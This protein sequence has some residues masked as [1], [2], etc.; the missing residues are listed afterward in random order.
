MKRWIPLFAVLM[1]GCETS[2]PDV[3]NTRWGMSPEQVKDTETA[4]L[5]S[6]KEYELDY[7][8]WMEGARWVE[9]Q[10]RFYGDALSRVVVDINSLTDSFHVDVLRILTEKYGPP[11][12]K[13]DQEDRLGTTLIRKWITPRTN[14]RFQAD[15]M[16]GIEIWYEK[17]PPTL[18]ESKSQF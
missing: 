16:G 5:S 8:D 18:E 9:I 11:I 3:R 4:V 17:R 6:E 14:I 10:Y 7:M 15:P 13:D 12:E 1:L 2:P